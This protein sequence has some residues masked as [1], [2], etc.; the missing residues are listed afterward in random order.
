MKVFLILLGIFSAAIVQAKSENAS[1]ERL[2]MQS[3]AMAGSRLDTDQVKR[4]EDDVAKK[5]DDVS[6][7]CKLLGYYFMKRHNSAEAKQAYRG[8][9]LWFIKNHPESEIAGTPFCELDPIT[10]PDGYHDAKQVWMKQIESHAKDAVILGNAARF[11]L[12]CD[13][14]L[15]EKLLK[16]AKEVEPKNPDW[17][18]LLGHFYTLQHDN[19]S[20]AKAL[21]ELEEAE[22]VDT[23]DESKSVRLKELAK[24]AYEAGEIEK[25]T[26]YAEKL[27]KTGTKDPQNWNYGNAIHQGNNVLGRI[28]LKQG[29]IPQANE[30]LLKAGKTPGSPQLNSFGPNMSLAKELLEAGQKDTVLQYFALCRKFWKSGG[31]ELDEWTKLVEKGQVPKFGANLSY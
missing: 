8:H 2:L 30:Y 24:S 13:K 17:P 15:A 22:A 5:P 7:R 19:D 16:Q 9:V 1:S 31:D 11:F 21:T 6:A 3:D 18:D 14:Q 27:L 20:S 29:H 4:L 28:A 12:L 10:D 25:A 23:S 26:K